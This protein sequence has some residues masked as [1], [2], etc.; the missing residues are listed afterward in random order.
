MEIFLALEQFPPLFYSSVIILGLLVGSFLNVVIHRLP[1]M[2]HRSWKDDCL[3]FLFEKFP[4]VLNASLSHATS[5]AHEGYNLVVPRSACPHCGHKITAIENIPVLSYLFLKGACRACKA[6]IS[7]RYPLIEILSAVM[8]TTVAWKFGLSFEALFAALLSW[9][10]ISLTFIDYDHQY[11]PDQITLPFLW[12]GLLI[13]LNGMFTDIHSALLGTVG[14]YLALWTVFH[15]FKLITKKEGMGFGDFKLLAMLGA[16]LGW[17]QLPVIILLSSV[18]GSIVGIGL[19]VFKQHE[20]GKPIPFGPYLAGAG[21]IALLW[22]K[23][24]NQ[25]YFNFVL[26]TG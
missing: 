1:V 10:L 21:W 23:E 12:L 17:Q 2:L 16:W 19:I 13:N 7:V 14:G 20:R 5:K 8:A 25:L 9:S 15:I 3:E 24:I 22:G 4:D 6:K 11:L 26:G 18:I